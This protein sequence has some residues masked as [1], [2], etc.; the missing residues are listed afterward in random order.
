MPSPRVPMDLNWNAEDRERLADHRP[1]TFASL[2]DSLGVAVFAI[3][4]LATM[5]AGRNLTASL[6]VASYC[7]GS[8]VPLL[9]VAFWWTSTL[10]PE[11]EDVNSMYANAGA[12]MLGM[13]AVL[14]GLGAILGSI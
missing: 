12:Q 5:A 14:L 8:A 11:G 1:W 10:E 9:G 2:V 6:L 4:Q 7:F 3:L 13:F